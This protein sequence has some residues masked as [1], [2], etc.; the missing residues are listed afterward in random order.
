VKVRGDK[1]ERRKLFA[2]LDLS[3]RLKGHEVSAASLELAVWVA[4]MLDGYMGE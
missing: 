3:D 4:V 1:L 2:R